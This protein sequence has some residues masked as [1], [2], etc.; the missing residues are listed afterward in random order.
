MRQTIN[1]LLKFLLGMPKFLVGMPKF[2]QE[3]QSP[4]LLGQEVEAPAWG[5]NWEMQLL[6]PLGQELVF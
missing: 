4:A 5:R 1:S 6:L 3:R 2:P